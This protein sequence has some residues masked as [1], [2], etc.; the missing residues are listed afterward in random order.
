VQEDRPNK[1]PETPFQRRSKTV[2][3]LPSH[4]QIVG[5]CLLHI[6]HI[7]CT[8]GILNREQIRIIRRAPSNQK[9]G[10][11]LKATVEENIW[12]LPLQRTSADDRKFHDTYWPPTVCTTHFKSPRNTHQC[13]CTVQTKCGNPLPATVEEHT[14]IWRLPLQVASADDRKLHDTYWLPTPYTTYFKSPTNTHQCKSTV[15]S[16]I[17]KPPNSDGRRSYGDYRRKEHRHMIGNCILRIDHLPSTRCILNR[18]Q[19]RIS[20]RG[21]SKQKSGNP[22]P[23]TVEDRMASTAARSIARLS[24]TACYILT[25]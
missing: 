25:T 1:N 2:W 10:N 22:L 19:I 15:Q 21:P 18:Q 20:A 24:E 12:R 13:K 3:R 9:S 4:R 14:R 16:N 5:N 11:P 7:T 6:D 8:R 23:A 17:R